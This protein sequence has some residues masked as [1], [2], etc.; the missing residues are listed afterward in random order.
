M[1]GATTTGEYH[2]IV[3][4]PAME[5]RFNKLVVE[6]LDHKS[7]MEVVTGV[8]EIYA[9]HHKVKYKPEAVEALVYL[10]KNYTKDR[11]N[12]DVAIDFID[13]VGSYARMNNKRVVSLD[14]V[15]AMMK[16]M[17]AK[18]DIVVDRALPQVNIGFIQR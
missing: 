2:S 10:G 13:N 15:K 14:V 11:V 4:D 3:K 18:K 8:V 5:R 7:T 9:K 6:E 17:F 16:D 12:P 1:I